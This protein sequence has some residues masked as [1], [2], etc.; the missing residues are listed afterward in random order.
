MNTILYEISAD[1]QNLDTLL[2]ETGGEV[3]P[4]VQAI[5]DRLSA[6]SSNVGWL[7]KASIE[8]E[9]VADVYK[10]EIARLQKL[11]DRQTGKID[12][13]NQC[14][15]ATMKLNGVE[16]VQTE[17]GLVCL[18]KNGQPSITYTKGKEK[19]PDIFV[20]ERKVVEEITPDRQAIIAAYRAGDVGSFDEWGISVQ[21]GEHI[22]IR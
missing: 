18:T 7:V 15:I 9:N 16:R 2:D 13:I 8:S 12:L 6:D 1:L 10:A 14:L 11:R 3:T 19:L 22:R 4:E 5:M 20:K 17:V 21:F